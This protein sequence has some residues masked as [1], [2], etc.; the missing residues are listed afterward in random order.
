MVFIERAAVDVADFGSEFS[1]GDDAAG[2]VVEADLSGGEGADALGGDKEDFDAEGADVAHFSG[3]ESLEFG[4]AVAD[5]DEFDGFNVARGD[6]GE[7]AT[8]QMGALALEGGEGF[9]EVGKDGDAEADSSR[10]DKCDGDAP[11]GLAEGVVAGAV[12]GVEGPEPGLGGRSVAEL[13]APEPG[14]GGEGEE[15]LA[16]EGFDFFIDGGDDA[17]VGFD[18]GGEGF[19]SFLGVT[20]GLLDEFGGRFEERLPGAHGLEYSGVGTDGSGS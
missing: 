20:P 5:G 12:D 9:L 2:A 6:G 16:E 13:F 15:L 1:A 14:A 8:V 11:E 10:V 19:A 18:G 4:A 7:R 17:A 3:G